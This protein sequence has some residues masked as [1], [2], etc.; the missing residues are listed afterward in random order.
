[1]NVGF[2]PSRASLL[3]EELVDRRRGYSLLL[4]RVL[5]GMLLWL[6]I[7]G[8]VLA[9]EAGRV[10]SIVGRAEVLQAGQWQPVKWGRP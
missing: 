1:M 2:N 7:A 3:E 9:E 6:V 4:G 10:V 5:F 8:P